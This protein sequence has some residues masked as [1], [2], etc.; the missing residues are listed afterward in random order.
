[1]NNVVN[2]PNGKKKYKIIYADPPWTYLS[3]RTE[4]RGLIGLA[5][6]HYNTM[7]MAELKK[8]PVSDI[9]D[10]DC[11]LFLWITA[12]KMNEVFEL[13]KSWGFEYKTFAFN[14]IKTTNKGKPRCGLGWYTRSSSE[15]VLL[16]RKG[17][18]KRRSASVRQA[19]F[20]PLKR[21]SQKPAEVRDRIIQLCG[22]LPRI[23][24]FAREKTPG[25]DYW[26]NEIK[27]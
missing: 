7:S 5:Q 17:K 8:L 6:Q 2:F 23:E 14:W 16:A 3:D 13:I 21:H 11:M 25:W 26:G 19:I 22:D 18:F 4:K 15:F 9:A 27:N 24:L 12:P 10:D 20:S 1:M